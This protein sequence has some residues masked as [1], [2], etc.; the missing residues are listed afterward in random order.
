MPLKK[1]YSRRSISK[2]IARERLTRRKK[3]QAVAIALSTARKAA[4][5][6]GKPEKGP[7]P[8]PRD[9][10]RRKRRARLAKMRGRLK[11]IKE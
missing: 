1:G 6:A 2:N 9:E 3:G 7:G 11:G 4:E 10:E 5:K 8:S